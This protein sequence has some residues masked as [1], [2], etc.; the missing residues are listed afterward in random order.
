MKHIAPWLQKTEQELSQQSLR[1]HQV[2]AQKLR[3]QLTDSKSRCQQLEEDL[4]QRRIE[5][6]SLE[7]LFIEYEARHHPFG[8]LVASLQSTAVLAGRFSFGHVELFSQLWDATH[9]NIQ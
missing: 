3:K 6:A 7:L 2:E 8:C 4:H 1:M 5:R 9:Q